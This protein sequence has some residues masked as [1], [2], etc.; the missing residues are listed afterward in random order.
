MNQKVNLSVS[1]SSQAPILLMKTI[2]RDLKPFNK[3][4]PSM[5]T[6]GF[7]EHIDTEN[8][9]DKLIPQYERSLNAYW[10]Y[11]YVGEYEEGFINYDLKEEVVTLKITDFELISAENIIKML[12]PLPWTVANFYQITREGGWREYRAPRFGNG[13]GGLG[14]ACAFKGSGHDRLVSRRWLD[15]H[16]WYLI[17]DEKHDVSF[18]QFHEI[19]ADP[20]IALEQAM[21]GHRAMG[22]GFINKTHPFSNHPEKIY[23]EK[24]LRGIYFDSTGELH[25]VIPAGVPVTLE[26]MNDYC[27]AK[28]YSYFEQGTVKKLAF[29]FIEGKEAEPYLHDLWLRDIECLG[30]DPTGER[31]KVDENYHPDYEPPQWVKKLQQREHLDE[32]EEKKLELASVEKKIENLNQRV[33]NFSGGVLTGELNQNEALISRTKELEKELIEQRVIKQNIEKEITKLEE[34]NK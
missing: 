2:C 28:Y 15:Y 25:V 6:D 21:G 31:Y 17:R 26:Q 9:I 22:K 23:F 3:R 32:I 24:E 1:F 4:L 13:H 30:I 11:D 20:A 34:N 33:K 14:W 19:D 7:D 16:T 29:V 10:G 27:A 5:V 18:V 8:W 12:A